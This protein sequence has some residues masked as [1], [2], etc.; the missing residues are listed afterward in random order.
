ML[1][2]ILDN[3]RLHALAILCFS[4]AFFF[5]KDYFEN[6]REYVEKN[7]LAYI[8]GHLVSAGNEI[9]LPSGSSSGKHY[10]II[11]EAN[12]NF[13]PNSID[14]PAFVDEVPEGAVITMAYSPEEDPKATKKGIP[15]F[16]LKYNNK[17]YIKDADD[18]S[19][20]NNA[21]KK[22]RNTAIFVTLAGFAAIALVEFIRRKFFK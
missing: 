21:I 7:K 8:S 3:L 16:S 14:F 15:V 5:W 20:Y 19:W 12:R 9:Y 22:K 2:K 10:I 18:V 4:T 6:P 13:I 11:K 1:N 17:E